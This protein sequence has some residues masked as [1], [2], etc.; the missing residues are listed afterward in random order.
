MG[1]QPAR[2]GGI[3]VAS[4]TQRDTDAFLLILI[5]GEGDAVVPL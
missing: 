1:A 3:Q 2:K 5:L 4:P